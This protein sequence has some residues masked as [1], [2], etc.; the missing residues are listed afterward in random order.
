MEL[1]FGE[2]EPQEPVHARDE[3]GRVAAP[4][5]EPRAD[6][7]SLRELDANARAHGRAR[8]EE[9]PRALE[10]VGSLT[11]DRNPARR[12]LE[13]GRRQETELVLQRHR[14]HHRVD[15]V[16]AVRTAP[17]DPET[18][19]DLGGTADPEPARGR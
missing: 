4:A 6:G 13:G 17:Q 11:T 7:D 5:A 10:D 1:R 16:I 8:G 2:L 15:L 12:E 14:L 19:V 3:S 9:I 18:E